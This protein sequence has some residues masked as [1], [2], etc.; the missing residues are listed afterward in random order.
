M[1]NDLKNYKWEVPVKFRRLHANAKLPKYIHSGDAGMDVYLPV[2]YP[3]LSSG[4]IRIIPVGFAVEIP[5]GYELQVRP[6]SGLASRGINA[7]FGTIDSSFRNEV[8]VILTNN[9]HAIQPLN[10]GDRI[11][12][13]VLSRVPICA[14]EVVD[15]LEESERDG[16]FGSSGV[17]D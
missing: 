12:Q 10:M 13:L 7:H 11:A 17:S 6:R 14:W 4:E 15:E 9:S 5:A 3:P 16:G 2:S 1:L 8:G